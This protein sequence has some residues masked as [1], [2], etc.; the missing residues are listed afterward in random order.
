M[1][2]IADFHIHSKYSRACSKRLE[3]EAIAAWAQI[4]G[5]SVISCGDFTHPRWFADIEKK[6]EEAEPGLY[7]LKKNSHN[8]IRAVRQK[9]GIV[10]A[11]AP[12]PRFILTT[13]ISCIYRKGGSV[14]RVHMLVFAPSLEAVL[15][16]N[17]ALSTLGKLA[18][19]GRP[20]L[21]LDAKEL[22]KIV[23]DASP[24]C[25]VVPAHI[26]T[27]WF[28]IFGSKSGFNSIEEC[29]D[30]LAPHIFAAETG[31]SSDP[32]MN[33]HCSNLNSVTLISNSDAHSLEKLGREANV[34]EGSEISYALIRDALQ[35]K[36]CHLRLDYTVE[37]FPEEGRY[38]LDG[39]R[40]CGV[41]LDPAQT[42]KRKGLCPKCSKPLTVGV[43]HRVMELADQDPREQERR[44]SGFK[45][46]IP[47]QELIGQ[48]LRQGVNT[49]RVGELYAKVIN[50]FGSE[51]D[52]L[53]DT[54]IEA[55]QVFLP[56]EL[57][58]AVRNMRSGA[59][60]ITPGYDGVYGVINAIKP[61]ARRQSSLL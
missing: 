57:V 7:A 41:S 48:A 52:F 13:E 46:I 11:T 20:I 56:R 33:W 19:D 47:L 37:F 18:S 10:A 15:K 2:Y 34:F 43:L 51:F 12:L 6:L 24:D 21:G 1:R 32:R 58:N 4:K 29:F 53:L 55:M 45:N 8:E 14:R 39:H 16:I 59:V 31:L 61:S 38:H 50:R 9:S 23:M 42:R 36:K 28:A 22:L 30:E 40:D 17:L 49:K 26:W 54:P 5:I 3:L 60:E 25:Y 44:N 35:R 27:P